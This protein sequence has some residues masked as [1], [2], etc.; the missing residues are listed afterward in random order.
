M[1]LNQEKEVFAALPPQAE[2]LKSQ[3]GK[4]ERI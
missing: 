4:N 3:G 2:H 1:A